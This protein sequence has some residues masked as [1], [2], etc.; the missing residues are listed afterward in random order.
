MDNIINKPGCIQAT[1]R[2]MGDKWTPLIL[3]ELSRGP[4]TFSS[5]EA[6]LESISPRTLSQRLDMLENEDI[7]E[8]RLYCEH[9]P[10]FKYVLSAKGAELLDIL[11][12]MAE[13]GEKYQAAIPACDP[14]D[15]VRQ[16]GPTAI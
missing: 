5:L 15:Q 7:L 12:K 11:A 3:R 2:I 16:V 10:R 1:L 13:W 6:S 4:L 8:K 9:P 14:S